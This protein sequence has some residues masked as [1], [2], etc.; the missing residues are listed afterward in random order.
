MKTKSKILL[1]SIASIALCSSIAVG[2]T[3]ALFTSESQVNIAI[4]SGKV[5]VV[6]NAT[7]LTTYSMDVKQA[8]GTFENGGTASLVDNVLTL[9]NVTPGDKA[10][11]TINVENEST[12]SVK[13]RL[14]WDVAGDL[15]D[16]LEILANDAALAN[17]DWTNLAVG[18]DV[19]SIAVSVELPEEVGNKYQG[20]TASVSFLLEAVQANATPWVNITAGNLSKTDFTKEDTKFVFSGSFDAVTISELGNGSFIEFDNATVGAL[21]LQDD[22]ELTGTA[23]VA[24]FN[25]TRNNAEN[26]IEITFTDADIDIDGNVNVENTLGKSI[27]NIK[28]SSF[29]CAFLAV[30]THVNNN[31]GGL[32]E[33]NVVNSYLRCEEN[34]L[35]STITVWGRSGVKSTIYDSEI[36]TYSRGWHQSED[37]NDN[38]ITFQGAK[39]ID[40][41]IQR[42]NIHTY[43]YRSI[44]NARQYGSEDTTINASIDDSLIWIITK[45]THNP[46]T[47]PVWGF[48]SIT[49]TALVFTKNVTASV[50]QV[51]DSS[52]VYGNPVI[53]G[54]L[55]LHSNCNC[56]WDAHVALDDETVTFA[57]NAIV[58]VDDECNGSLTFVLSDSAKVVIDNGASVSGK[59]NIVAADGYTLNTVTENGVTTYSV[60]AI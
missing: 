29:E 55:N 56:S 51:V 57:P 20:K 37:A 58:S 21:T 60:T 52:F 16:G 18:E 54:N 25:A 22:A 28:N 1:S 42:S 45:S 53:H 41:D 47:I 11:F 36:H 40:I 31:R 23:T 17:V 4:T 12:I 30:G 8:E 26:P 35:G 32:A 48:D 43:G 49:D 19:A 6:A 33:F 39:S 14:T 44:I 46:E 59:V 9:T 24:S 7:A 3:F 13:Y 2:G 50:D 5:A 10:T 38:A 34:S 27:L 15:A